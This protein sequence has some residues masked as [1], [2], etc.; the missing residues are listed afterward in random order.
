LTPKIGGG[1]T[2]DVKGSK[3]KTYATFDYAYS[4]QY[5]YQET[6][7]ANTYWNK[8]RASMLRSEV[9]LN[10]T[11]IYECKDFSWKPGFTLGVVNKK[12]IKK[13]KIISPSAGSFESTTV[14]TTDISPGVESTWQFN[15]GYALSASWTGEFGSQYNL[16]EA[17][18]K[19]TK[20]F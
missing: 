13:G 5:G 7:A 14:T 8:S 20:K 1:Y 12:P 2:F 18:V 10:L 16:Q 6:G 19:F 9:G 17:S 4:T 11:Q 15:D 3:L